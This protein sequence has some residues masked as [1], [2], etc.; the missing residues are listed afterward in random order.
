MFS[1]TRVRDLA[2]EGVVIVVSI[3]LAFGL[4]AGWAAHGQRQEEVR[5]LGNLQVEFL[6]A[7]TQLD[8]YL[9]FHEVTL[10]SLENL[11]ASLQAQQS[12]GGHSAEV[13]TVDLGRAFI[14]PTFDPRL[15]TLEGL[16]HSGNTGL[17]KSEVLQ[18]TLSG[19]PGLLAEAAEEEARIDDLLMNH[20][21]PAIRKA[22]DV[23]DAHIMVVDIL[24]GA[25]AN[26]VWGRSCEDVE[27]EVGVPERWAGTLTIPV[28]SEVLSLFAARYQILF[29]GIDQYREVRS[30]IDLIL[31]QLE[32]S[33]PT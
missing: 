21:E 9:T 1:R 31:A 27:Q 16:L 8:R 15:G 2:I 18:K 26:V 3:L 5:L 23:S 14:S 25:C 12:A 32:E 19:W 11:L 30:E 7:G 24:D 22:A 17:F 4:E 6:E 28:N 29:H 13:A 33:L 20:L 10:G